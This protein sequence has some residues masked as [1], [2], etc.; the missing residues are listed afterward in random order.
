MKKIEPIEVWIPGRLPG[1]NEIIKAA[2]SGK[3]KGNA[4]ARLKEKWTGY[5][6]DIF[7]EAGID[8]L[9]EISLVFTWV[10]KDKRRDKDNISAAKKFILDGM[11]KAGVISND[12]W[13]NI[14]GWKDKFE[15]NPYSPGVNVLIIEQ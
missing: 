9:G 10:E 12:G 15:I 6:A 13:G 11:Q 7:T 1:E 8:P 2:K 3:G 14:A 4:Y 5:V